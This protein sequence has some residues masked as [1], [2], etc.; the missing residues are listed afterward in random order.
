MLECVEHLT[1]SEEYLLSQL[2]SARHS[3]ATSGDREREPRIISLGVDRSKRISCPDVAQPTGRFTTLREA[4]QHFL[5]SRRLTIQFV[6]HF[7]DDLRSNV[8][9]HPLVGSVNCYEMLLIMAVHPRR[10]AEQVK[11]IQATLQR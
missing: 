11:E 7:D 2:A 9:S 8:T 10:H 4:L 1:V 3:D 5:A 6:E